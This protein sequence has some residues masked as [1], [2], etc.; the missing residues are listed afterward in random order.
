MHGSS[1][2]HERSKSDQHKQALIVMMGV[3][4]WLLA[5]YNDGEQAVECFQVEH[6]NIAKN[7]ER[8]S[9]SKFCCLARLIFG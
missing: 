4:S 3:M 9:I 7:V 8:R 2:Q 5:V 1:T 6:K